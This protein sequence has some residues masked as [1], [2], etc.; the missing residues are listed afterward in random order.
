MT[1]R[2]G[3]LNGP[4]AWDGRSASPSRIH[5]LLLRYAPE[6]SLR[7]V[8]QQIQL[9]DQGSPVHRYEG[10]DAIADVGGNL[11]S[12]PLREAVRASEP[13]SRALD[14]ALRSLRAELEASGAVGV[15]DLELVL[16]A[17]GERIVRIAFALDLAPQ[18]VEGD[19]PH[20]AVR[21]GSQH[22]RHHAPAL[23]DLRDRLNPPPPGLLQRLRAGVQSLFG[24]P[25]S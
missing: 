4:V 10:I 20:P 1:R 22:I 25:R 23:D 16:D 19:A 7:I 21:G 5:D 3:P 18:D 17:D 11:V 12:V 8:L 13:D 6:G 24:L 14:E 9:Y 2:D 15:D